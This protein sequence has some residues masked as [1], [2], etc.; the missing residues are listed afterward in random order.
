[1]AVFGAA[2]SHQCP[3]RPIKT[4]RATSEESAFDRAW[5]RIWASAMPGPGAMSSRRVGGAVLC[6]STGDGLGSG[7]SNAGDR[8]AVGAFPEDVI[9]EAVV[10]AVGVGGVEAGLQVVDEAVRRSVGK[11]KLC[12]QDLEPPSERT[13]GDPTAVLIRAAV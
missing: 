10:V 7:G 11:R 2:A 3:L 1:M 8:G 13:T 5:R 9:G 4:E 6:P 12:F